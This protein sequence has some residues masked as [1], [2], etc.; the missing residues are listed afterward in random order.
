[1]SPEKSAFLDIAELPR[2]FLRS[3]WTAGQAGG[4]WD[5]K[6]G[7]ALTQGNILSTYQL[8]YRGNRG[9]ALGSAQRGWGLGRLA[10]RL[11]L[12]RLRRGRGPGGALLHQGARSRAS[13]PPAGQRGGF[14]HGCITPSAG[15]RSAA[16]SLPSLSA[17]P[18]AS[19]DD[20]R[21]PDLKL[22]GAVLRCRPFPTASNGAHPRGNTN[23]LTLPLGQWEIVACRCRLIDHMWV[24]SIKVF[25]NRVLKSSGGVVGGAAL[26]VIWWKPHGLSVLR[27][28][29]GLRRKT[30]QGLL[31]T[32]TLQISCDSRG[33]PTGNSF[34]Q[35]RSGLKRSGSR[36][37]S[38][39][40]VASPSLVSEVVGGGQ[41]AEYAKLLGLG[42]ALPE[43]WKR[44]A[45]L[46][47]EKEKDS[48]IEEEKFHCSVASKVRELLKFWVSSDTSTQQL[49]RNLYVLGFVLALRKQRLFKCFCGSVEGRDEA[50]LTSTCE[51]MEGSTASLPGLHMSYKGDMHAVPCCPFLT[52]APA[53]RWT[54][55]VD[56]LNYPYIYGCHLIGEEGPMWRTP[57]EKE[58]KARDNAK[59]N[60]IFSATD[61]V[62]ILWLSHNETEAESLIMQPPSK[63]KHLL[64]DLS[65]IVRSGSDPETGAS[66]RAILLPALDSWPLESTAGL[67]EAPVLFLEFSSLGSQCSKTFKHWFIW[68]ILV[69]MSRLSAFLGY[70]AGKTHV[71]R[72]VDRPG[73]K[74]HKK[75]VVEPV[76]IVE[77]MPF[78][79]V[80]TVGCVETL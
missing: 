74:L 61:S 24:Y 15:D 9:P 35:G 36:G 14:V 5:L 27:V 55:Q 64:I 75:E 71:V 62:Y 68:T 40:P 30:P 44:K 49:F 47:K 63:W 56:G 38:E 76:T 67:Q 17:A 34:S 23:H 39:T 46:Q 66:E 57:Q 69:H 59:D 37:R 2:L 21:T 19:E 4:A 54:H 52:Q 42:I 58:A 11:V 48:N 50:A 43:T 65:V 25:F 72:K 33:L 73:S 53:V 7:Q 6:K 60:A 79:P 13:D 3:S 80:G 12:L 51:K 18:R 45:K 8:R 77:T 28:N 41:S 10:C 70:K 26:L 22:S 1:M 20:L 32:L 16:V 29:A 78:M 31:E